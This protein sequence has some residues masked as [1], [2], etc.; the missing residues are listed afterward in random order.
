MP[1]SRTRRGPFLIAPGPISPRVGISSF[2][3]AFSYTFCDRS[4]GLLGKPTPGRWATD[5]AGS[6]PHR[7]V[8]GDEPRPSYPEE[9][10]S[11]GGEG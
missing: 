6:R 1:L 4:I 11:W 2:R 8:D 3:N 7:D 10:A 9:P 5:D